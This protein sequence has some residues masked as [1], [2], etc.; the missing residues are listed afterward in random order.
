M[1]VTLRPVVNLNFLDESALRSFSLSRV[2][3]YNFWQKNIGSKAAGETDPLSQF[4]QHFI[5]V[6]FFQAQIAKVQ[7]KTDDL[8]VFFALLGSVH[9]KAACKMLVKSTLGFYFS[10]RSSP[11]G[12]GMSIGCQFHQR[13]TRSF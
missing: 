9:V 13:F 2:F 6:Q 5:Y 4:H 1:L 7:K 11:V 12:G 3:L 8:T 10:G